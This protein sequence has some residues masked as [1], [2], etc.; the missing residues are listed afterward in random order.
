MAVAVCYAVVDTKSVS[1]DE[2]HALLIC[3]PDPTKTLLNAL[4]A[5]DTP[6]MVFKITVNATIAALFDVGDPIVV[7]AALTG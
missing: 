2:T 4:W 6:G 7:S 1:E 3:V 5:Y